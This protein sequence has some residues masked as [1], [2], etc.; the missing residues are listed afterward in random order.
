MNNLFLL[1]T[2]SKLKR[3]TNDRVVAKFR[4]LSGKEQQD[5]EVIDARKGKASLRDKIDDMDN[6]VS[7]HFLSAMPHIMTNH[8]I[9]KTYRYGR[10]VSADGVPQIISEE[11]II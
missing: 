3:Y 9:G 1:S 8:K 11:V 2:V 4:E 6:I 5:S 7:D 10:Q